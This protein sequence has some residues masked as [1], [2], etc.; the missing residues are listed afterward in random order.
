MYV[1]CKLSYVVRYIIFYLRQSVQSQLKLFYHFLFVR[2]AKQQLCIVKAIV[3]QP[4]FRQK[5][6]AYK[7][8]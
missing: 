4:S 8:A 3:G 5:L 7:Y 2:K 6:L 1:I